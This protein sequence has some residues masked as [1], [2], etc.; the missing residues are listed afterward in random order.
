MKPTVLQLIDE[1]YDLGS[2]ENFLERYTEDSIHKTIENEESYV[3]HLGAIFR[4]FHTP[5]GSLRGAFLLDNVVTENRRRE[6]LFTKLYREFEEEN[7]E[8]EIFL[9]FPL[10]EELLHLVD[11]QGYEIVGEVPVFAK[12]LNPRHIVK[13]NFLLRGFVS[14]ISKMVEGLSSVWRKKN[15]VDTSQVTLQEVKE[16]SPEVEALWERVK[17][18]FPIMSERTLDFI[19]GKMRSFGKYILW[20]ARENNQ[21]TGYLM[22]RYIERGEIRYLMIMDMLWETKATEKALYDV[23]EERGKAMDVSLI[24]AW[25]TKKNSQALM[26]RQFRFAKSSI[27]TVAKAKVDMNIKDMDLW[28]LQPIEGEVY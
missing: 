27:V 3:A 2:Y 26:E 8:R 7:P 25:K 22:A 24:G 20:E 28:H 4:D 14:A 17:K 6:G 9:T 11:H 10:Q 21:L 23:C 19:H 16:F 18:D 1:I 13:G 15:R 12:V 5:K